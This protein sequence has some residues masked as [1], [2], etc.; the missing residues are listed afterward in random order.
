MPKCSGAAGEES[1]PH[2][3]YVT[4]LP[5]WSTHLLTSID[6]AYGRSA[7]ILADIEAPLP[8]SI[9]ASYST[10]QQYPA[11][12]DYS[13]MQGGW[14]GGVE[15]AGLIGTDAENYFWTTFMPDSSGPNF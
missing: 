9:D 2:P 11:Q 5:P 12:P 15:P 3:R 4:S 6:T 8:A 10:Y 1:V 14:F 7:G 13:A